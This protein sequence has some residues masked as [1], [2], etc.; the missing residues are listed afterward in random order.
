M[1]YYCQTVELQEKAILLFLHH[2]NQTTQIKQMGEVIG[3]RVWEAREDNMI[4]MDFELVENKSCAI[5]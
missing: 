4:L 2:W 3:Y 1:A 5:Q